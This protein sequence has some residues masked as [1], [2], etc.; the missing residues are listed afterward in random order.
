MYD[1]SIKNIVRKRVDGFDWMLDVA[2]GGIGAVLARSDTSGVGTDFAREKLFMMTLD[3][4]VEPGMVCVD[5]GAN[6]GYATMIMAR[7]STNPR[8]VYAIEPDS[9][10][11]KC[12]K[13]N[14]KLNRYGDCNIYR[15]V[16]SNHSGESDFWIAR[17]PNLNSVSKTRHSI[18]KEK[19]KCTTLGSFCRD[20]GIYPNFIKMDIEG[21]ETKVFEGAFDFFKE[22]GGSTHFLLE[23]H[24]KMYG[25]ENDFASMLKKY[26][27]IGFRI[28]ALIATPVEDPEPFLSRGYK[29]EIKTKSDGW[30]RS[31]YTDVR[32]E[33]AI[34]LCTNLH[35]T[36]P[37]KKCVRSI[38]VSREG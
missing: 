13:R 28:S 4:V 32:S 26:E 34:F 23:V 37:G 15:A 17:H 14:L 24:P 2:D 25:A 1:D 36:V 27:T 20:R 5:V 7:N 21:H 30:Y 12:L 6:I 31:L 38:L 29:P 3:M 10:N 9:H 19:I 22:E 18:R 8:N 33:D 11:I 16:V 35:D